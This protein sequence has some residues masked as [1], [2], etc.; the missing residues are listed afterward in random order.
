MVHRSKLALLA[1]FLILSGC[2]PFGDRTEPT[3]LFPADSVSRAIAAD[4]SPAE[5]QLLQR[6]QTQESSF[7]GS[8]Q[9]GPDSLIWIGD[10]ATSSIRRFALDGTE[11]SALASEHLVYPY[12]AGASGDSV[13]VFDVGRESLLLIDSGA[14]ETVTELPAR[15]GGNQL[16]RFVAVR[17]GV[18]YVKDTGAADQ[19]TMATVSGD[20]S[21][22][23]S[24]L[25]G[26]SW[27]YH[28]IMRSWGDRVMGVASYHPMLYMFDDD[29]GLD[30]LRLSGFD[31]PM[32]ARSRSFALGETDQPPL[33][34]SGAAA[35]D[36][37]LYV[38]N[39][40]P[41]IIRIDEYDVNGDL[42]RVFQRESPEPDPFTPVDLIVL[43]DT[44]G[45]LLFVVASTFAEYGSI[46]LDYRSRL[47]FY[48]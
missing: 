38:I 47:D 34:I 7:W 27:R 35:I 16:S 1:A 40:R 45:G 29:A 23:R 20:G 2:S 44:D 4:V 36:D 22:R 5:L 17:G 48:R 11:Q 13:Y 24:V 6:I 46:S 32:L 42:Q 3:E 19:A 15:V 26:P 31:S 10:L 39:V 14:I 21:V 33:M 28:G 9:F 30:S 12:L 18:A 37:L 8:I 43:P 41:G 25:P